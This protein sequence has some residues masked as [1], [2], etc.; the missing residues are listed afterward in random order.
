[1]SAPPIVLL[2]FSSKLWGRHEELGVGYVA[3][4][5]E[6]AGYPVEVVTVD[7]ESDELFAFFSRTRNAPVLIGVAFSHA[8]I[9]LEVL[10]TVLATCR[11][12]V[13]TSHITAGGYFATFNSERLLD[14]LPE[15]DSVV[16]GEGE[17]TIVELADRLRAQ[18]DLSELSGLRTRT[19]SYSPRAPI[20]DLDAL[21]PPKRAPVEA[22]LRSIF[23]LSTSRGCLAHCT[24]CNVPAWTRHH[25]GGWRGRSPVNIVDELEGLTQMQPFP[26]VWVVDS[27]Y[28]DSEIGGLQRI[29]RIAEEILKRNLALRYYVFFRAETICEPDFSLVLPLLVESGMR[30]VFVGVET[31][32]DQELKAFAKH[33]RAASNRAALEILR[34]ANVAVRAGWIMFTPQMQL[35]DLAA[36]LDQL[37]DFELLHS[38]IDL[39]TCLEVYSG[40]SEVQ[41]LRKLGFL[42]ENAWH[43]PFAY[44]FADPRVDVLARAMVAIRTAEGHRWDGEALHTTDLVIAAARHEITRAAATD[45]TREMVNEADS[46]VSKIKRIQVAANRLFFEELI[47]LVATRWDQSQFLS[48][49][50]QHVRDYH[51]PTARAART[52]A[53]KLISDLGE[54]GVQ[55]HY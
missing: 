32:D 28:E 53:A 5:A 6:A 41:K 23:S 10:D 24:F 2:S 34:T 37:E 30:R 47:D 31:G 45:D 50:Q 22:G 42:H 4:A 48:R 21:E 55:V 16:V 20:K 29:E 39:F 7:P 54:R 35:E 51:L 25:G 3:A 14:A 26:R 52:V 17:K 36:K 43:D 19:H 1:M 44:D 33:S 15:L 18:R 49:V 11:T 46:K 8:A 40:S 13:P 12:A 9:S 27:S 38:T